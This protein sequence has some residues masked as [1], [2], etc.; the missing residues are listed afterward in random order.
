MDILLRVFLA[1]MLAGVLA[2]GVLITA[3]SFLY[4]LYHGMTLAGHRERH[5][6]PTPG[7]A[8]TYLVSAYT[9]QRAQI[10]LLRAEVEAYK[11]ALAP[12][13]GMTFTFVPGLEMLNTVHGPER[14]ALLA[15]IDRLADELAT[16]VADCSQYHVGRDEMAAATTERDT[17]LA[18]VDSLSLQLEAAQGALAI[19]MAENT[20]KG[21]LLDRITAWDMANQPAN[22]TN[23]AYWAAEIDT[24]YVKLGQVDWTIDHKDTL[25]L[26]QK[27]TLQLRELHKH[28]KVTAP[29]ETFS[30]A[31]VVYLFEELLK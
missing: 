18:R 25:G 13:R 7:N 26:R 20:A 3:I 16:K 8:W 17:A 30:I 28:Q 24:L 4:S 22:H 21:E 1:G 15:E 31:T 12:L 27:I 10:D 29:G 9:R 6:P 19:V 2:W 11:K 14:E 5:V 23:G